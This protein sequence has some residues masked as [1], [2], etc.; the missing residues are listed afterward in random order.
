MKKI[1]LASLAFALSWSGTAFAQTEVDALRYTQLGVAGSARTQGIGGAQTALGADVSNL[2]G[3]PAG[4]GMFR[5]SEFSI[6][7]A[8]Q[9]STSDARAN[10]TS[11]SDERSMLTIPQA[12]LILSNRKGD[13]DDSD[14]RGLNFGIGFTRLNN[15]NQ[16][17]SYQNSFFVPEDPDFV[18]KTIVDYFATTLDDLAYRTYL[19]DI[20]EDDEGEY[21]SPLYMS[22]D[23]AQSEVIERRGS[24]NQID[25]GVGTSYQDK[26]YIGASLGILTTNFTQK[27][28]FLESGRYIYEYSENESEPHV[29]DNYSLELY[30]EFTT[31]GAGIN[32]K[33]GVIARPIDALRIGGSI[34]TPTA[35]TLTDAYQRSLYSSLINPDT[36]VPGDFNASDDPGEFSY[37]LTTPFRATGGV[38]VFIGKYGFITGDVEYVNYANSRFNEDDEFGTGTTGFFTNLNNNISNIYQSAMNYKIGAEGRYEAFRVRVGYAYAGDPYQSA[39]LDGAVKSFSVGA[40]VRLQNYYADL[41]FVSSKSDSRF[42]P[43]QFSSEGGEPMV[44]VANRQNSVLLTVGYNF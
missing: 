39:A 1:V 24:Q 33:V 21:G 15:F 17:I 7:P 34:Q 41:A 4:I 31:R 44:D 23:V 29:Y 40:G 37:R 20:F 30:D 28:T 19:I 18:P 14:W 11:Q 43:Y 35:Y 25:I 5:R 13:E 3:N 26:I 16:R 8:L 2:A 27:S 32:L 12:S 22:G 9:Y 36:G 10:G 38:A 42:S 6:T